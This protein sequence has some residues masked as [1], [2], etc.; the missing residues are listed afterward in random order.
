L[1]RLSGSAARSGARGAA[2]RVERRRRVSHRAPAP[3]PRRRV[4]APPRR[5]AAAP[6]RR[7]AAAP[8]RRR[9]AACLLL[10]LGFA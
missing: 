2:T 7:R 8:P 6:P 5:R 10:D 1:S 9:A 3:A 4:A